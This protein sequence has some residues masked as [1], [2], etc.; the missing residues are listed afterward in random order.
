MPALTERTLVARIN[1]ALR[2]DDADMIVRVCRDSSRDR[3][4]LGR[5]YAVDPTR[6]CIV[7]KHVDLEAL[8]RALSVLR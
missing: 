6:N 8:A 7:D 1:R 4:Y 2:R 3:L 5:Y